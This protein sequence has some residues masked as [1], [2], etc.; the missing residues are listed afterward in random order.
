MAGISIDPSRREVSL[1]ARCGV[2]LGGLE[3]QEPRI[4][5][6]EAVDGCPA[7]WGGHTTPD[8]L[9][10]PV[11]KPWFKDCRVSAKRGFGVS[12][13][14]ERQSGAVYGEKRTR[15]REGSKTPKINEPA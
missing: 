12:S 9:D 2:D 1:V 11:L 14:I 4:V 5:V 15:A 10:P 3:V 6:R 7:L 13:V 8:A